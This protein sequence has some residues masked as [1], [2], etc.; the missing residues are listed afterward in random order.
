MCL[1]VSAAARCAVPVWLAV[2]GSYDQG[3]PHRGVHT[4]DS[5]DRT[6]RIKPALRSRIDR[7]RAFGSHSC[8]SAVVVMMEES[9]K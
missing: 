5:T 2:A 6:H 8:V 9:R 3:Q 7:I 4:S 1:H